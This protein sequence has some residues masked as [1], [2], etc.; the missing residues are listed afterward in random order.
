M[1]KDGHSYLGVMASN[2]E[3]SDPSQWIIYINDK[4]R[5][6]RIIWYGTPERIMPYL[7]DEY[8]RVCGHMDPGDNLP[9]WYYYDGKT[10]HIESNYEHGP[11]HKIIDDDAVPAVKTILWDNIHLED[12]FTE[13][14]VDQWIQTMKKATS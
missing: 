6:K 2:F 5:C 4:T 9:L 10:A 1:P 11:D 14:P 8:D 3:L 13:I 12:D 7:F